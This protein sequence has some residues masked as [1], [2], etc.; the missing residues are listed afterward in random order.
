[1]CSGPMTFKLHELNVVASDDIAFSLGL[2]RCG[3][4]DKDGEE[5]ASWMNVTIGYRKSHGA[6]VHEHFSAPFDM[7]NGKALLELQP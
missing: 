5:H 7:E 2:N 6:C 1:M 4:T 3:G